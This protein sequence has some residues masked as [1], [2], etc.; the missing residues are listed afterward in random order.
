MGICIAASG[1]LTADKR[2]IDSTVVMN[3]DSQELLANMMLLLAA[4]GSTTD[5][6]LENR[7]TIGGPFRD[8][9]LSLPN[10]IRPC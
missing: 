8:R 1:V 5:T 9:L 7:T 4:F 6:M 2:V 3:G 10:D